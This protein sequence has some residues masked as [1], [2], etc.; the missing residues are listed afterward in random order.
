MR[1]ENKNERKARTHFL[2]NQSIDRWKSTGTSWK[3]QA[4][5]LPENKNQIQLS[6]RKIITGPGRCSRQH[7]RHNQAHRCTQRTM[8]APRNSG[9]NQLNHIAIPRNGTTADSVKLYFSTQCGEK[10]E[11]YRCV[12]RITLPCS[13]TPAALARGSCDT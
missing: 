13:R 4:Y 12:A 8:S 2:C 1:I 7:S 10:N 6:L 3:R 5:S 9:T 11:K